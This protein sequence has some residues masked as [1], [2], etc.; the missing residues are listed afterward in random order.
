MVVKKQS[1][2]NVNFKN[3]EAFYAYLPQ[4]E[5][6]MTLFLKRL[7]LEAIPSLHERLSYNVPFF[8]GNKNIAFLWPASV[9]WGKKQTY[10]GV[11]IG[12]TQ[13]FRLTDPNQLLEKGN[14][15]QVYYKTY[16]DL[17]AIENDVEILRSLILE[18]ALLDKKIL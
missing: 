3:L 5:L 12:F 4:E 1:F 17:K 13:G 2:Q 9:L 8:K 16:Q 6:E 14:R 18:A 10:N 7:L 11:R 15:K